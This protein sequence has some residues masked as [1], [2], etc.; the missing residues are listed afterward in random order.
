MLY[1]VGV[2]PVRERE[3]ERETAY[4]LQLQKP[5]RIGQK[6]CKNKEGR[7]LESETKKKKKYHQKKYNDLVY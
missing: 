5:N 2:L 3:R 4:S 7:G 1:E 6:R